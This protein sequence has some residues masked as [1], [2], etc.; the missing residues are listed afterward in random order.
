MFTNQKIRMVVCNLMG[1]LIKDKGESVSLFYNTIQQIQ[2]SLIPSNVH[3]LH[4]NSIR[5]IIPS[6]ISQSN[7]EI[8]KRTLKDIRNEYETNLLK[9][10]QSTSSVTLVHPKIP[11]YLENLRSHGIKV[12]IITDYDS[13]LHTWLL[14]KFELNWYLDDWISRDSM[15]VSHS[16]PNIVQTFMQRHSM[17]RSREVILISDNHK[18]IE[19]GKRANC[20]TVGTLSGEDTEITLSYTFPDLVLDN[21]VYLRIVK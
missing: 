5:N 17:E 11:L 3:S 9:T 7:Q 8:H 21:I 2:P 14:D 16:H 1:T 18:D 15:Y 6:Y 4:K 10:Y 19:I 12:C 20:Y 13:Q